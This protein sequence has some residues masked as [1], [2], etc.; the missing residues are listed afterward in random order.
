MGKLEGIRLTAV[1]AAAATLT[2][3][4]ER[5]PTRICVDNQGRRIADVGCVPVRSAAGGAG[6]AIA[7]RGGWYYLNSSQ[8]SQGGAP[9][10]GG[11][12]QGGS[13]A[14]EA[15]TSYGA[16]PEGGIARGGFGGT[17]DDGGHGGEG[18]GHGGGGE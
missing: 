18:G 7:A 4:S 8:V 17:G 1:L 12:A 2:A 15:G 16:A 13:F 11:A 9:A 3:C 14:P 10:L 6:G 5:H